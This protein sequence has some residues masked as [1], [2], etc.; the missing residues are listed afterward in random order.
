MNWGFI[1]ISYVSLLAFGLADNIRGP[2]FLEVL[3]SYQLS[4]FIGSF[5]FAASSFMALIASLMSSFWSRYFHQYRLLQFGLIFMSVGFCGMGLAK[6]YPQMLI[7]VCAFGVSVGLLSISQNYL[8]SVGTTEQHRSRALSGLHAMYGLA[9]LTAPLVASTFSQKQWSWQEI[10]IFV[11]ILPLV[12]LFGSFFKAAPKL[13]KSVMNFN[14]EANSINKNKLFMFAMSFSLYVVAEI[15]VSSRLALYLRRDYNYDLPESSQALLIFFILLLIGR[16]LSS[17]VNWGT[18]L[19]KALLWS[20]GTTAVALSLG[21][22]VHP[23]FLVLAGL[24]MAPFYPLA[25]SFIS[26]IF[27]NH[28][29]MAIGWAMS[30]QSLC[31]VSMHLVVGRFSDNFGLAAALWLGPMA[32]FISFFLIQFG[33][34]LDEAK[35]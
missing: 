27:P 33:V 21:L 35:S 5:V 6:T 10:F 8:V 30:L 19:R 17:F 26:E 7:F 24:T 4:D 2:L 14:D 13:K 34:R 1:I 12:V 3:R 15:L 9:S 16:G 25:I 22:L 11:G 32:C 20:L 18:A 29:Q 28:V 23:G 31:V